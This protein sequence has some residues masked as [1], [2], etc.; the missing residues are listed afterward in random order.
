MASKLPLPTDL[1]ALVASYAAYSPTPSA[2]ALRKYLETHP[3]IKG[4]VAACPRIHPGLIIL[5]APDLG[6]V[7]CS[8]CSTCAKARHFQIRQ[9]YTAS[10]L[11]EPSSTS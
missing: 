11:C 2:A 6:L 9:R 5:G 1:H 3:W 7:D 10:S 8:K 4:M